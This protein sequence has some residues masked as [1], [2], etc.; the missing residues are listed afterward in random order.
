MTLRSQTDKVVTSESLTDSSIAPRRKPDLN[1]R[2]DKRFL[3]RGYRVI[4]G[5]KTSKGSK[6]HLFIKLF[7]FFCFCDNAHGIAL[8]IIH[9][10]V[11]MTL[12][13]MTNLIMMN[14]QFF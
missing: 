3:H 13:F 5:T 14:F 11:H 7:S 6:W 9:K 8:N 1:V 4:I 2:F 12:V 10:I